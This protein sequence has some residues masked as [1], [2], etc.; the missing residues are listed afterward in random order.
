MMCLS[1]AKKIALG[2]CKVQNIRRAG[3]TSS[4]SPTTYFV[5]LVNRAIICCVDLAQTIFAVSLPAYVW[6]VLC[7]RLPILM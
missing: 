3:M 1:N 2:G 7:V 4:F 6:F 5:A